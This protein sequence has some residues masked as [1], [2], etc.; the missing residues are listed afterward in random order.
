MDSSTSPLVGLLVLIVI[1]VVGPLTGA[2]ARRKG[3]GFATWWVGGVVLF[4]IAQ[5]YVFVFAKSYE[6][7]IEQ[8]YGRECPYCAERIKPKA[9]VCRFCGRDIGSD[10]RFAPNA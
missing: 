8:A 10:R 4:P 6:A 5:I 9:V 3:L 2:A 7:G 1:F